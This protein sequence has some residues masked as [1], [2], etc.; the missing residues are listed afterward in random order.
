MGDLRETT[1]V[2]R[3]G[4]ECLRSLATVTS[5]GAL[6]HVFAALLDVFEKA[7]WQH[8]DTIVEAFASISD[9]AARATH[10]P[11]PVVR[12][13]LTY[14]ETL[15]APEISV[16]PDGRKGGLFGRLAS[17]F[18]E[19]KERHRSVKLLRW[20]AGALTVLE[21]YMSQAVDGPG[22]A[23]RQAPAPASA[24]ANHD[25]HHHSLDEDLN[26]LLAVQLFLCVVA[27]HDHRVA[28][29]DLLLPLIGDHAP[30]PAYA[31][32]ADAGAALLP[33]SRDR[34]GQT[35]AD[36]LSQIHLEEGESSTG[37]ERAVDAL[38]SMKEVTDGAVE[39]VCKLVWRCVAHVARR[40]MPVGR[41]RADVLPGV[42]QYLEVAENRIRSLCERVAEGGGRVD[43]D[44]DSFEVVGLGAAAAAAAAEDDADDHA[45]RL[46]QGRDG[47]LVSVDDHARAGNADARA[48]APAGAGAGAAARRSQAVATLQRIC[49]N[50][51][52][53]LRVYV[54]YT[55]NILLTA[56]TELSGSAMAADGLQPLTAEAVCHLCLLAQAGEPSVTRQALCV[57]LHLLRGSAAAGSD[58]RNP[59][60]PLTAVQVAL[61]RDVIFSV[62]C[63]CP[64][65]P[66]LALSALAAW[67][68][69]VALLRSFGA[70]EVIS[71]LPQLLTL[72]D[73]WTALQDGGASDEATVD[74]LCTQRLF[75]AAYLQQVARQFDAP[76]ARKIAD[77]LM[78]QW[79][80]AGALPVAVSAMQPPSHSSLASFVVAEFGAAARADVDLVL[81]PTGLLSE[82]RQKVAVAAV[83]R[84]ELL[85][86]LAAGTGLR[87]EA[88]AVKAAFGVRYVPRDDPYVRLEELAAAGAGAAAAHDPADSP[89]RLSR[90]A[91]SAHQAQAP[92]LSAAGRRGRSPS[93]NRSH[94]RSVGSR[95]STAA[96]RRAKAAA[97]NA[98]FVP[99][100]TPALRPASYT[101]KYQ[102][103][104]AAGDTSGGGS[105]GWLGQRGTAANPVQALLAALDDLAL[106]RRGRQ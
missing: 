62:L 10:H 46:A 106:S 35:G 71:G 59:W 81:N 85:A 33:S 65:R 12:V 93:S 24:A 70:A 30:A 19:K 51:V 78:K 95:R 103:V 89:V 27:R 92:P 73:Y 99:D 14:A 45:A 42:L 6:T 48:R 29:A 80:D 50:V 34:G 47:D 88:P 44:G 77:G 49:A 52:T 20:V 28:D 25:H 86:A 60:A 5:P 56:S 41:A 72:E 32:L 61:V 2:R 40:H 84:A 55:A 98:A 31:K 74:V 37:A 94:S 38:R 105:G 87:S 4:W 8:V 90:S 101:D 17:V 11:A 21:L 23:G 66:I 79:G 75:F 102:A 69:Q 36:I 13:L 64:S 76:A 63:A 16:A 96:S 18:A 57:F 3:V 53:T 68:L 15:V 58:G 82:P 43:M 83:N 104:S 39:S 97:N 7:E 54:L 26:R 100:L 91:L 22:G 9:A 1:A 67:A